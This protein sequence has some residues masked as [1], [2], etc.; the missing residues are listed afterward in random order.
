M[1]DDGRA[2]SGASRGRGAAPRPNRTS[3]SSGRW[4]TSTTSG[5]ATTASCSASAQA[6]RERIARE[7]LPVVDNLERSLE[8]AKADDDPLVVGVR[9]VLEQAVGVLARLGFPR[10]DDT[11]RAFDPSRHE[12][13]GA[14]PSDGRP[15]DDRGHRPRRL[16]Q[17]RTGC[18]GRRA[19]SS[20]SARSGRPDGRPR[21]LLRRARRVARRDRRRDPA[22]LPE[23]GED[24]PPRRQQG[25]GRRRSLQGDLR[26]VR[27]AVGS[28]DAR[29]ATTPS[30]TT[31]AG[32]PRA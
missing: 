31:S 26:G 8:F 14:V 16:R 21:R 24:V 22:R 27:R 30:G 19:W 6:E 29:R 3:S 9:A 18:C 11:G 1:P 23:A 7:W 25:P 5:S 28:R 32:C 12:A 2:R 13:V 10:F 4:L 15:G 20:P 17:T